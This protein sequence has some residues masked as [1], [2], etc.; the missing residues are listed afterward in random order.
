MEKICSGNVLQLA[1]IHKLI[2]N[3]KLQ[4]RSG[5]DSGFPCD[6]QKIRN[7]KYS[8]RVSPQESKRGKGI[9]NENLAPSMS[10]FLAT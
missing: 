4:S 1:D 2:C 5:R 10:Y 7:G 8:H 9:A 6:F 3:I